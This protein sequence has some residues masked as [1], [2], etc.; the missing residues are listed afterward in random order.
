MQGFVEHKNGLIFIFCKYIFN[1]TT[2]CNRHNILLLGY[3]LVTTG[4]PYKTGKHSEVIDLGNSEMICDLLPDFPIQTK[5]STGGL[6]NEFTPL[7]CGGDNLNDKCYTIGQFEPLTELHSGPNY[8]QSVVLN[9]DTLWVVGHDG[10]TEYVY[11]DEQSEPGPKL[12]QWVK[13]GK[14]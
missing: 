14:N 10:N 11:L 3:L 4:T 12:P 6:L 13:N 8:L 9:T 7:I 2:L 5:G 1:F